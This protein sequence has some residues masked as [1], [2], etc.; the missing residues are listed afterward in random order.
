MLA[1]YR[2]VVIGAFNEVELGL[3]T[4][5]CCAPSPD[6]SGGRRA[7]AEESLRIAEARYREGAGQ[8][9]TL[10]AAQ[11]TLYGARE[12][13]LNNK[14]G[15]LQAVVGLYRALGGGWRLQAP[16]TAVE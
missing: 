10:L 15:V 2:Q 11:T 16:P 14:L 8:F 7:L 13:L 12:A 9:E 4:W 1:D 6:V 3:R 5:A